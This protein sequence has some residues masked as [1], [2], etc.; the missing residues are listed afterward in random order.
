MIWLIPTPIGNLE[1]ITYRAVRLL[2]EVDLIAAEDTRTSS[3]L[4]K[5]LGISTPMTALHKFNEHQIIEKLLEQ[6]L[7]GKKLAVISD[8]GTPGISDP[9]FLIVRAA[10]EKGIP[11][12]CLPGATAFVPALVVSGLPC[13]TFVFEGFLPVKKGR[14][15]KLKSLAEEHRTIVLYE[16]PYRMKKTL[17][18]LAQ[19]LGPNRKASFSREISKKFEETQRG[20]L[21]ELAKLC[22]LK[23][24]KGEC[25]IV[26][27]GKKTNGSTS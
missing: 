8:A 11:V 9:G 25:V 14:Q 27:A 19:Y 24:P 4:L 5:H 13:D 21:E 15:T 18:E 17:E 2:Q 23:E 6:V 26:V 3:I 12:Q 7:D 20:T 1:D 16:S 22:A 10:V